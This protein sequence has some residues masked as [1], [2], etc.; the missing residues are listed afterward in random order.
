MVLESPLMPEPVED[1]SLRPC[2]LPGAQPEDLRAGEP[3]RGSSQ[4]PATNP[5]AA[6][7]QTTTALLLPRVPGSVKPQ[8]PSISS[9][10]TTHRQPPLLPARSTR[11]P[12]QPQS[13]RQFRRQINV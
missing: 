12:H 4:P 13:R 3:T 9:R 10:I 11:G 7:R 8:S 1:P 5:A 6:W 2:L